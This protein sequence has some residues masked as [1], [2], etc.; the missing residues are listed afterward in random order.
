MFLH[1]MHRKPIQFGKIGISAN[2]MNSE[3]YA[4][5][6]QTYSNVLINDATGPCV[7][8]PLNGI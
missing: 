5:M 4:V 8:C 2:V 1:K 6:S 3:S 7:W